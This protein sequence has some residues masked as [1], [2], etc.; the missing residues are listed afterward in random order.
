M[1]GTFCVAFATLASCSSSGTHDHAVDGAATSDTPNADTTVVRDDD[2][3]GLDDALETQLANDYMPFVS[4]DPADGC[5]RDGFVVRVRPHPADATKIQIIYDHLL[6]H[7][8]G[9]NGHVGDDEVFGIAIDPAKP[10]P[11]GILAIRAVSHQ[12]TPCERDTQCSTCGGA[13]TRAACDLA[14]DGNAMWPVVYSSKDKHGNY[15]SMSQCP[16]LGTCLDQCTLNAHRVHPPLVNA[17]EPGKPLVTDLTDQG[18]ITAANGWTEPTLMHFDPWNA[19]TN[20]GGAGNIA[21]DLKDPAF[22]AAICP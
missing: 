5:S 3:D 14:S 2:G 1:R 4:F 13:D 22:L 8:C 17:G 11:T 12:N 6:E 16:L 15:A 18:F 10:A 21:S 20:F 9:L 19:T 7:D